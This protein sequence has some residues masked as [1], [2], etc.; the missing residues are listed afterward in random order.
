M[1]PNRAPRIEIPRGLTA[2]LATGAI[3]IAG[4]G[5]EKPSSET[6]ATGTVPA[7]AGTPHHH[8]KTKAAATSTPE[9]TATATPEQNS[10]SSDVES[11]VQKMHDV[12]YGGGTVPVLKPETAEEAILWASNGVKDE[13]LTPLGL[14]MDDLKKVLENGTPEEVD[15]IQQNPQLPEAKWPHIKINAEVEPSDGQL[16]FTI[17]PPEITSTQ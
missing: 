8:H 3:A 11:L 9:A 10:S 15:I 5:A 14:T 6:A 1:K 12:G 7:T 13:V 16:K 17:T 4:C 2:L